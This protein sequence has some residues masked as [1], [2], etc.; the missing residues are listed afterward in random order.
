M[1]V[2]VVAFTLS[3]A[4]KTTPCVTAAP[5]YGNSQH[6]QHR[7]NDHGRNQTCQWLQNFHQ[8]S[9]IHENQ[10]TSDCLKLEKLL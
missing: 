2:V 8:L 7:P 3:T 5:T 1:S 6:T 9:P 4:P 10:H